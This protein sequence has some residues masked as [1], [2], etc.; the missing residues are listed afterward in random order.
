MSAKKKLA[1]IKDG[2]FPSQLRGVTKTTAYNCKRVQGA[3]GKYHVKLYEQES[4]VSKLDGI[5]PNFASHTDAGKVFAGY[6]EMKSELRTL[7]QNA[8]MACPN[9]KEV[10]CNNV[11]KN[12]A[13]LDNK[14]AAQEKE[15]ARLKCNKLAE[16]ALLA[17][18]ES[19]ASASKALELVSERYTFA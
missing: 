12:V 8:M 5:I 9:M 11:K 18:K 15:L 17:F 2:R 4:D 3:V 7:Y 14:I 16:Q 13:A 1:L 6:Y 19:F 10:T